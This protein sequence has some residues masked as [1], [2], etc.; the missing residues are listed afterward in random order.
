MKLE[1]ITTD[2]TSPC[3]ILTEKKY[4]CI[5]LLNFTFSEV[6]EIFE[7]PLHGSSKTFRLKASMNMLGMLVSILTWLE[8]FILRDHLV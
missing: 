7:F 5:D 8:F 6:L 4:L 1:N 2:M 3:M